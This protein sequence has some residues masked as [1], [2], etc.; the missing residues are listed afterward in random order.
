M[1]L[2][3]SSVLHPMTVEL[4]SAAICRMTRMRITWERSKGK[5]L[6]LSSW[7]W[8]RIVAVCRSSEHF[9][10][11]GAGADNVPKGL[12]IDHVKNLKF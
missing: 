10:E 8:T 3:G 12:L 6:L 11:A 1:L 4:G 5:K 9:M 7:R 2:R